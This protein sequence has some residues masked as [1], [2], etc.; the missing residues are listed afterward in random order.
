MSLAALSWEDIE[1]MMNFFV[2]LL[3]VVAF[4]LFLIALEEQPPDSFILPD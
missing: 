1:R 4:S 2:A 3:A